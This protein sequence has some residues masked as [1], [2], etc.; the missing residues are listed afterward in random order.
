M[1]IG[2]I[3]SDQC[4]F[5]SLG[6]VLLE[7]TDVHVP[8]CMFDAEQSEPALGGIFLCLKPVSAQLER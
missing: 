3:C 6:S 4:R 7:L 1:L 2:L 5:D 8:F